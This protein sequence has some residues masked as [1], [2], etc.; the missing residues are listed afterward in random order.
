M[1][2]PSLAELAAEAKHAEERLA[3]DRRKMLLGRGDAR[4]LAERQRVAEGARD[5]LRRE[6]ERAKQDPAT[7]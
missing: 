2:E 1:A 7:P 4:R 6:Q 3:L 5:R